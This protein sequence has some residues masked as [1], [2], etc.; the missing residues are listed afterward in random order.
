MNYDD[1]NIIAEYDENG[2]VIASYVHGPN[3]DEPLSAIIK[4]GC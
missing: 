1:Q 3:I 4:L 2:K